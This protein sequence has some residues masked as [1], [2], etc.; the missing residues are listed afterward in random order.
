MPSFKIIGL[1]FLEKKIIEG[2]NHIWV[3]WPSCSCGLDNLY[4]LSFPLSNGGSKR[5]L[6]LICK[7]VSEKKIFENGGW[8]MDNS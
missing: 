6:A 7:V 8:R 5:N 2:L 3:W 1:L 4:K